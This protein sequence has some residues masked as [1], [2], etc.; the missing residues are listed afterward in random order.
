MN[1]TTR[2]KIPES[3]ED[4]A[5]TFCPRDLNFREECDEFRCGAKLSWKEGF[6]AGAEYERARIVSLLRSEETKKEWLNSYPEGYV[7]T[8]TDFADWIEKGKLK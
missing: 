3:L 7:V 1:P 8:D 2:D 4:P 6:L 5:E